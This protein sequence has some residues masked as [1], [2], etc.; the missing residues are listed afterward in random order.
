MPPCPGVLIYLDDG[1]AGM[2]ALNALC[3]STYMDVY[4]VEVHAGGLASVIL[5]WAISISVPLLCAISVGDH[6]ID[7]SWSGDGLWQPMSPAAA[8]VGFAA[9]L[10]PSIQEASGRNTER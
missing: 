2:H 8:L 9:D 6:E 5:S 3:D 7:P 1:L 10:L 4:E